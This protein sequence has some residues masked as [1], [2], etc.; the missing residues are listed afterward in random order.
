MLEKN[1]NSFSWSFMNVIPKTTQK[2]QSW[3]DPDLWRAYNL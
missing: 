2:I 1:K 3:N